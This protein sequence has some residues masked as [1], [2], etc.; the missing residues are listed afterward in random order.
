[1]SPPEYLPHGY[2]LRS[3]KSVMVTAA[4]K[5][6]NNLL[7]FKIVPS[8]KISNLLE[9][10]FVDPLIEAIAPCAPAHP[11]ISIVVS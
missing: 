3:T 2:D 5:L 4:E 10:V 11:C 8:L 9:V 6:L 7:A 1:M